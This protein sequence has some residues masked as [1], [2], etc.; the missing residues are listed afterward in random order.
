MRVVEGE[1]VDFLAELE[2]EVEEEGGL[3][4]GSVPVARHG[5]DKGRMGGYA[6]VVVWECGGVGVCETI[7][8]NEKCSDSPALMTDFVRW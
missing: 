7:Y 4:V 3:T 5:G 1:G 6:S 2:G 8:D